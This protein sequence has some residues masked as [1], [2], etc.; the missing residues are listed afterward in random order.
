MADPVAASLRCLPRAVR[1]ALRRRAQELATETYWRTLIDLHKQ[2]EAGEIT[3][4][5][6]RDWRPAEAGAGRR[7]G[8][9]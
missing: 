5:K 6:V 9:C 4:D 1:R 7:V 8:R 3:A 2:L